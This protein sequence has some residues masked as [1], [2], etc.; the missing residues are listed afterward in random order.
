MAIPMQRGGQR[1]EYNNYV[2]LQRKVDEY[3][4]KCAENDEFPDEKG[5]YLYLR[6][7]KED[8]EVKCEDSYPGHEE[9]RRILKEAQYQRESWLARHMVSDAKRA[10]G[11]MNALKQEQNGAWI[12]RPDKKQQTVKVELPA[13]MSWDSFK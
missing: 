6:V 1:P 9:Y 2:D 8:L 5:M 4:N 12:D 3:F 11:C 10:N 13:G 7:F